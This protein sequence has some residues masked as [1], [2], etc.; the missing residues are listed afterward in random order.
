MNTLQQFEEFIVEKS[1]QGIWRKCP[2]CGEKIWDGIHNENAT[3]FSI[4][5]SQKMPGH[6]D[7]SDWKSKFGK[8]SWQFGTLKN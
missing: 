2:Y 6:T 8:G 1:D 3:G 7:K 5:V 4:H